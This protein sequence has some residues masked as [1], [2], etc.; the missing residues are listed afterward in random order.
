MT[1]PLTTAANG[2]PHP[3][4][5][6]FEEWVKWREEK[7]WKGLLANIHPEGAVPG[8]V[9][10]SPSKVKPDYWYQWTRD[11]A[12]VMKTVLDSYLKG[13]KEFRK[14]IDE[15]ID[16]T[17]IMQHKETPLGGFAT[18]GLGEVK[19]HVNNEPFTGEWSRPQNDG[20]ALRVITLS[21]FANHLLDQGT[22]A[23]KEYVKT[24]LYD[25]KLNTQS[26]IKGDLEHVAKEWATPGYDLWEEVRGSHFYTLLAIYQG[27]Y[28]GGLLASRLG[29]T[30]AAARYIDESSKVLAVLPSFWSPTKGIIRVT[31][32]HGKG[33]ESVEN[34]HVGDDTYGKVSELDAAVLLATL[35]AGEGTEW[36]GSEKVLATLEELSKAMLAVYPLNKSR[37]VP[38]IGRYPEDEY[39][40]TGLSLAHP[41]FLCTAS[42]AEVLYRSASA[43]EKSTE[44]L[45]IT[46]VGKRHFGRWTTESIVQPGS[47]EMSKI[48]Q[49]QRE[50]GD[51]FLEIVKEFGPSDGSLHEQFDRVTG[52]G[53]GAR[54]LTWSYAASI[55]ALEARRGE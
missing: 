18:G 42:A 45:V 21:R 46:D 47:E 31:K 37:K 24:V 50:L 41:W 28:Q 38:C 19:F 10:A 25:S 44:E 39:D 53:R 20:P 33:R 32:D 13:R 26:V 16:A 11:S 34:A 43:L 23:E 6:N 35:H 1:R 49:G 55:T 15:Y 54:D 51:Q 52:V 48:V 14:L 4:K 7:S 3:K 12:L 9:V 22:D 36:L 30:V 40:G 2:V 5:M 17:R 29:D 27:L 8:C